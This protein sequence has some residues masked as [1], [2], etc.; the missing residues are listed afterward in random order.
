M[1]LSQEIHNEYIIQYNQNQTKKN[2]NAQEANCRF[3]SIKQN[4][5]NICGERG[6]MLE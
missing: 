1:T 6:A 3:A 5:L 2:C 4:E